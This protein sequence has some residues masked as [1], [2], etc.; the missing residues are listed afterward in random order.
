MK[1]LATFG[2]LVVQAAL[3]YLGARFQASSVARIREGRYRSLAGYLWTPAYLLLTFTG[4]WLLTG[5]FPLAFILILIGAALLTNFIYT[6]L[7]AVYGFTQEENLEKTNVLP[8]IW[9]F[10]MG[11][12]NRYLNCAHISGALLMLLASIVGSLWVFWSRPFGDPAARVWIVLWAFTIPALVYRLLPLIYTWP[13]ITSEYLDNDVRNAYLAS[14]FAN[15]IYL[16]IYLLFPLWVFEQDVGLVFTN[17]PPFWVLLSI[18]LLL[19]LLAYAVPFFIGWLRYRARIETMLE[20]RRDWLNDLLGFVKLP[21]GE[22]RTKGVQG[23]FDE[24]KSEIDKR[25]EGNE[26][27]QV[28]RDLISPDFARDERLLE[29]PEGEE[30][31]AVEVIAPSVDDTSPFSRFSQATLSLAD[32]N[33]A[34]QNIFDILDEHKQNLVVWDLRFN[35][36]AKL[37][38]LHQRT[39]DGIAADISGFIEHRL[40]EI[41]RQAEKL[42]RRRNLAAPSLSALSAAAVWLFN[43]LEDE[44]IAFITGLVR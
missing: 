24:L 30:G 5:I 19:F 3:L 36:V 40:K 2:F 6:L 16:T 7:G 20:W 43:I 10:I 42:T 14:G 32:E 37:V 44:I 34:N 28:Y 11:V 21:A 17:L 8:I 31:P 12:R 25:L 41:D 39:L 4:F 9:G 18:P 27:F 15:L 33:P 35:D 23:K 38:E 1:I 29:A 22:V 13:Y 26:V